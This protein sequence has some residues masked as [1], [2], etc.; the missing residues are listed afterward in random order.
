MLNQNE[1]IDRLHKV[2]EYY[3]LSAATFAE[4]I[5]VQRSSISHILSGRNKPSLEFI[6]KM[7]NTYDAIT[8]DWLVNGEGSFPKE[9]NNK[10]ETTSPL[11]K[12]TIDQPNLFSDNLKETVKENDK[13]EEFTKIV[14]EVAL[15]KK[16]TPSAIERIVIFYENGTFKEYI[17]G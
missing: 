10:E 14:S 16:T 11:P 1:F 12:E 13:T 15:Q 17:K 8:L 4:E 3:N 9:L 2:F 7:V 6:L 5:K